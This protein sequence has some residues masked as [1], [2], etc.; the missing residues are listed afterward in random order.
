[1]K[2]KILLFLAI[3]SFVNFINAQNQPPVA[4]NDTVWALYNTKEQINVRDNDID[5][6]GGILR[7]DTIFYTGEAEVSFHKFGYVFYTGPT[8]FYGLDSLQYI[9]HDTDEPIM[10]DTAWVFITVRRKDFENLDINNINAFIGKDANIFRNDLFG[11]TSAAYEVP[12]GSGNSTIFTFAPWLAGFVNDSIKLNA[13]RFL[14][15]ILDYPLTGPI[16]DVQWYSEYDEKWDRLWKVD[17]SD[18]EYHISHWADA[19]YQP[20]EVIANWPAHGDTD[21][22]QA[23]Y[24]APFVDYNNDGIYNPMDGDYPKIKGDQAV[25]LI[26]NLIRP[27]ILNSQ[28]EEPEDIPI[29]LESISNTEVHGMFYAFDCE[30]DSALNH[31][32][33]ANIKFINRTDETYT[34]AYLGLWA[35]LDIG[36]ANNDYIECDV[37]RSSFFGYNGTDFDPGQYGASG[38]GA[39]LPAQSVTLLKGIKMD[40]D[41]MDNAFGVGENESVNGL[42]F[43]DGIVDN[44]YWGMNHFVFHNN[45]TGPGATQ[46]PITS[47]D[48]YNY[49]HAIWKDGTPMTYGGTGYQPNNPNAIPAK[50]MFPGDSDPYFY[51]TAGIEVPMWT[52]INSGNAPRDRRGVSSTGPFTLMPFDTAEVDIAFV[53]GRDYTGSGNL[54]PIPIM[55][56]RID[57]ILSYYL[58]GQTPCGS[59][60]VAVEEF[61]KDE[62]APIFSVYPNPFTDFITLDNQSREN[63]EI[64]IYNLL[65]KELLRKTVPVGKTRIN[66][67]QISENALIIKAI[68]KDSIEAKKLLRVR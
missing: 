62:L 51:G 29:P 59:F 38:Y 27:Y 37:M 10:Y 40:D 26:Y 9:V 28:A 2:N 13:F 7:I 23:F 53:F 66:L 44:E 43:E 17:Q 4:V 15:Y 61:E 3:F 55:K 68:T 47:G 5:P 42:N 67:A 60:A 58:A 16:M 34:D 52:D 22:G 21:K 31:T 24:I 65:G 1:M 14:Q 45:A 11:N 25:Y 12:K 20:I 48:Y 8:G 33:F 46:D 49:L 50:F 41:G 19:N 35:D 63:M 30:I 56:E 6:E 32:V 36:L 64:V 18:I 54:A 39:N 57:S